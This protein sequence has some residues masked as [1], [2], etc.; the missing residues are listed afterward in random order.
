MVIFARLFNPAFSVNRLT[1]LLLLMTTCVPVLQHT[2]YAQFNSLVAF[3]LALTYY[4]LHR[5]KYLL[6][7]L[8][9]GTM[10]FKPQV[11]LVTIL[12]LLIWSGLKRERRLFWLGL[13]LTAAVL[14]AA[15]EM[16]ERNWVVTFVQGLASY[17]PVLSVMDRV[18]NPY[19]L[20]SLSLVGITV[21][22]AVRLREY[23]ARSV[24][25]TVLLAWTV[26]LTA[27]VIPIF[28]MLNIVLMGPVFVILLHGYARLYPAYTRYL[29]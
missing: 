22:L 24:Q 5:Q 14:W 17:P 19:Q 1:W 21:G 18:W 29:W 8:W 13:A 7:G 4:G 28:G 16:L 6:A 20:V 2:I 26:C 9:A 23:P 10:L 3:A 25:F 11:A 12:T 15:P 27:L